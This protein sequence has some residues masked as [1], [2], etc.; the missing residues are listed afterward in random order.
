MREKECEVEKEFVMW[1]V[2][3]VRNFLQI[4]VMNLIEELQQIFKNDDDEEVIV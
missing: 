1:L 4:E 3:K 2:G